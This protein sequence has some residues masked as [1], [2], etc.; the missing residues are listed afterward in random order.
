MPVLQAHNISCQF[1]NGTVLF[2]DI[3][4]SLTQRRV[5]LV[6]RNGIG[7]SLLLSLFSKEFLPSSG[8]VTLNSSFATYR[9]QSN[10][11][12]LSG[13]TIA[14][15]LNLDKVLAALDLIAQ[16]RC[17]QHLFDIVGD[18]WDLK[19]T[20]AK[21][22]LGLGIPADPN[23]PCGNLSGGQMAKLQLWQLFQA[24]PGLL[25]LDEP[26]NHLDSEGKRWLIE[27]MGAFGGYILLVSHDRQLLNEM[28]QIWELSSLG[29][30]QFG[31]NYDFYFEQTNLEREALAR[32][33]KAVCRQQR[34]LEVEAQK[35][36]EK[37][38]QRAA[39]GNRTRKQG[40]QPK[41]MLDFKRGNAEKAA[42]SRSKNEVLRG[43]QLQQKATELGAKLEEAG[44][45]KMY[46]ANSDLGN[47]VLVNI[48]NG[49]LPHGIR[50][51]ID[52]QLNSRTKLHLKG[53][54][55]SGK[56]TLMQVLLGQLPLN[57]GDVSVNA[58][59]CYLDQHFG[60]LQLE[61]TILENLMDQCEGMD[62]TKARTL[63]SG[64]GF[65]RDSVYQ[66]AGLLSGGEKMK[67]AMLIVGQRRS[68]ALLLLDEPDNHL[69]IDSKMQLANLLRDYKSAYILVSH[70]DDFVLEAG[71][72]DE[73]Y[74]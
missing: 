52:L 36:R 47:K 49:Q 38:E 3:C 53:N 25:L 63:L 43:K 69:D 14:Q 19:D 18:S 40:S 33:I 13:R 61:H 70:D 74:L 71:V 26:S 62:E 30:K 66:R 57:S 21:Q 45:Q 55:G 48:V 5:G 56:S 27:A 51:S 12:A 67:L 50:T 28:E 35:N 23:L 31:G 60:L 29:L 22:L 58:P 8:S 4:C 11:D 6:G 68:P 54:N 32:Q 73:F 16:G 24:N 64:I 42:S 9:Q 59:C 72:T 15:Y 10:Q 1:E 41:V 65:R 37:A 34:K 46:M 39:Q 7:K 17:E 44:Q 2:Q 20:L